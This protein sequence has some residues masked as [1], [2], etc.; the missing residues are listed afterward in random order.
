M[1]AWLGTTMRSYCGCLRV[2]VDVDAMGYD[3]EMAP[4]A[5]ATAEGYAD[6]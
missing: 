5:A 6:G 3:E 4:M 1:I 2:G